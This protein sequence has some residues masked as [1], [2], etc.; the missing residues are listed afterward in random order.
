MKRI[1]APEIIGQIA[2]KNEQWFV[3]FDFKPLEGLESN[4]LMLMYG[5][6]MKI[7]AQFSAALDRKNLN[8][9]ISALTKKFFNRIIERYS[10]FDLRGLEE[11]SFWL[12]QLGTD[13]WPRVEIDR[14]YPLEKI[15]NSVLEDLIHILIER[16]QTIY[17]SEL[18]VGISGA[19]GIPLVD[20]MPVSRSVGSR[21]DSFMR[22]MVEYSNISSGAKLTVLILSRQ[23]GVPLPKEIII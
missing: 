18:I 5:E 4:R 8:S 11:F 3:D 9:F 1:Q 16:G 14:T 21:S 20:G 12:E 22:F 13:S 15:D 6:W 10:I 19:A 2:L 7:L 23:R 17:G